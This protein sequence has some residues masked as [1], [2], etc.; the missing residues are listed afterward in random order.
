MEL[1]VKVIFNFSASRVQSYEFSVL[2]F[3]EYVDR[4]SS[5][6]NKYTIY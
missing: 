2:Y 4:Y 3:I 6:T 5:F 1:G